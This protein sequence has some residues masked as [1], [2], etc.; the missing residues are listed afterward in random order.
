MQSIQE[1]CLDHFVVLGERRFDF[2]T[3]GG[4]TAF[5][6][7]FEYASLFV[8]TAPTLITRMGPLG[9]ITDPDPVALRGIAVIGLSGTATGTWQFSV[10]NG[11][12]W[13]TIP[14]TA[15]LLASDSSTRIRYVPNPGFT[16]TVAL[17]FTAWDRTQGLLNGSIVN[18]G[19]RGG[20]TPFSLNHDTAT[21]NVTN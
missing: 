11:A 16:G 1:E 8:N 9:S 21:L 13:S 19:L 7:P 12:S 18:A 10:N 5:S 15:L 6:T 3:R 17:A 14:A 4:T 20:A 2:L